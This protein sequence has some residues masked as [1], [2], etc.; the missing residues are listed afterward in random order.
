M[1]ELEWTAPASA[2]LLAIVDAIADEN[3][4]AA[5]RLLDDVDAKLAALIQ[6]PQLYRAGRVD[7]TRE[8]VVWA[9]YIVVYAENPLTVTV[10]RVL[11][12]TRQW[13]P[14]EEGPIE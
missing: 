11:H 12:A 14:V 2:D 10:L 8:M 5:Q 3:L 13:P 6:F 1:P 9:N 7:G 4:V